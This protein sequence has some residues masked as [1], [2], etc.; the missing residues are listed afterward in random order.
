MGLGTVRAL[1]GLLSL[2]ATL[3]LTPVGHTNVIFHV[4]D[5]M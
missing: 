5:D 3:T 2:G 4:Q 1:P